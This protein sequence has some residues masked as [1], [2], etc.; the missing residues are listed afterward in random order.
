MRSNYNHSADTVVWVDN[1]HGHFSNRI[2]SEIIAEALNAG[3]G[4]ERLPNGN[5]IF[6]PHKRDGN[7]G[8]SK[9]AGPFGSA[10]QEEPVFFR[11]PSGSLSYY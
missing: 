3:S 1:Q 9:R 5:A 2:S 11:L 6:K 4:A 8:S 7:S 10:Q